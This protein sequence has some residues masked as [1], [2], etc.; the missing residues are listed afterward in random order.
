MEKFICQKPMFSKTKDEKILIRMSLSNFLSFEEVWEHISFNNSMKLIG[1]LPYYFHPMQEWYLC[2][3]WVENLYNPVPDLRYELENF[4]LPFPKYYL[5]LTFSIYYFILDY[6]Y[7]EH[8][9]KVNFN[10]NELFLFKQNITDLKRKQFI[11][12]NQKVFKKSGIDNSDALGT[13]IFVKITFRPG[14]KR[15]N[16]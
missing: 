13:K 9:V 11:K 10:I 16:N 12:F 6:K 7:K 8:K 1:L 15:S 14:K 5:N 4:N 2:N 3:G